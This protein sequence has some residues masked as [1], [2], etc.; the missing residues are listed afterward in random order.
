MA[1]HPCYVCAP[2]SCGRKPGESP[3]SWA[4]HKLLGGIGVEP[5]QQRQ[6]A[7]IGRGRPRLPLGAHVLQNSCSLSRRPWLRQVADEL[8]RD[9]EPTPWTLRTIQVRRTWSSCLRHSQLGCTML[10]D[11]TSRAILQQWIAAKVTQG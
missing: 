11:W 3:P 4:A 2:K 5:G 6:Q 10:R 1:A 8:R 9:V 7:L